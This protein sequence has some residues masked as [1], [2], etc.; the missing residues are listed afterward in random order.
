MVDARRRLLLFGAVDELVD[1]L[2]SDQMRADGASVVNLQPWLDAGSAE[3]VLASQRLLVC[4]RLQADDAI[5]CHA[6]NSNNNTE[7]PRSS[8]IRDSNEFRLVVTDVAK[9]FD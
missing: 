6:L 8:R 4:G 5:G 9:F 7:E 2:V 1:W 3:P